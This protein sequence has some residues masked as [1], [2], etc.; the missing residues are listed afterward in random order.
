MA[1]GLALLIAIWWAGSLI[2]GSALLLPTPPEAF[3]AL[4]RIS[5]KPGFLSDLGATGLRVLI[6]FALSFAL[7]LAA[8]VASGISSAAKSMFSPLLAALRTIPFISLSVLSIIWFPSGTV[9]IFVAFLMA[10]P[11]VASDVSEGLGS[12]DAGL[13]EMSRVFKVPRFNMIRGLY[14]PSITPYLVSAGAQSLGMSWKIVVSAEVLSIPSKGIGARMDAARAFLETPELF[15]W[16]L[17][18]VILG[19]IA[20]LTLGALMARSFRRKE[21]KQCQG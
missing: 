14:L 11:I 10:F 15:A 3:R 13:I 18:L 19:F 1:A 8:G 2:I 12:V 7:G 6:A 5:A 4:I 21:G 16:T 9:P 17:L 20:D